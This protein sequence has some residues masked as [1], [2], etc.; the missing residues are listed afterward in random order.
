[1]ES[2][3]TANGCTA[4]VYYVSPTQL[5]ILTPPNALSGS[6]PV[7]VFSQWSGLYAEDHGAGA[8]R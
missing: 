1:M 8:V 2:V 6:V 3:I 4:Y 5:N 7:Q